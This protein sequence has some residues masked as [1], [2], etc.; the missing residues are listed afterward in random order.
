MEPLQHD[1]FKKRRMRR[2][3]FI[4]LSMAV[5]MAF[6]FSIASAA[7]LMKISLKWEYKD[8]APQITIHEPKGTAPLWSMGNVK[9]ESDA[10]IGALIKGDTILM[11]KGSTRKLVLAVRNDTGEPIFFF[12][13]P[14]FMSPPEGALGFKFK[15][16]C[17]NHAF[18]IDPGKTWF[19]VVELRASEHV[20]GNELAVT[21]AIV[22][23][24]RSRAEDFI[25]GKRAEP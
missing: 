14:H 15:C 12:A 8:F 11:A 17:V 2:T 7:E 6:H 22:G 16:L 10:P 1:I 25:L 18:K 13:A 3:R 23:L 19:R 21:H 4:W 20:M 24:E 5:G 9:D